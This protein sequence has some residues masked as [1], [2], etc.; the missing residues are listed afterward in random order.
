MGNV[1][2]YEGQT[3]IGD[4]FNTIRDKVMTPYTTG[5]NNWSVA[6][7]VDGLLILKLTTENGKEA[8]IEFSRITG[9]D[10]NDLRG[11]ICIRYSDTIESG[12]L[13]LPSVKSY[14][15]FG[16]NAGQGGV[17]KRTNDMYTD[18]FISMNNNYLALSIK[19]DPV[20]DYTKYHNSFM[21]FGAIVPFNDSDIDG[22]IALTTSYRRGLPYMDGGLT[23]YDHYSFVG[24]DQRIYGTYTSRGMDEISMLKTYSKLRYQKHYPS[25]LFNGDVV[26][27]VAQLTSSGR[28]NNFFFSA[29]KWSD[30]FH[31]SPIYVTHP[32]EGYRGYLENVIS[33]N[34][35]SL[36]ERDIL[37]ENVGTDLAP[38]YQT[39]KLIFIHQNGSYNFMSSMK[40]N[41]YIV[42]MRM[43]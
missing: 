16:G 1:A 32:Y 5:T 25:V 29:S 42:A 18:Y 22:N 20:L 23:S 4:L 34:P 35:Q 6:K 33:V 30:K 12:N 19:G 27:D 28:P 31:A 17:F 36:L 7:D 37:Q 13:I 3:T 2:Y 9:G 11:T 26:D 15:T 24:D 38:I 10:A 39:Y 43:T 14:L 40:T 8:Y 41:K 21:Y